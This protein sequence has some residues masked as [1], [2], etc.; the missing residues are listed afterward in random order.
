MTLIICD[1]VSLWSQFQPHLSHPL[2]LESVSLWSQAQVL[3]KD[4]EFDPNLPLIT[5]A[6]RKLDLYNPEMPNH[7]QTEEESK[8]MEALTN[9]A[10]ISGP[11]GP[12]WWAALHDCFESSTFIVAPLVH[13]ALNTSDLYLI[14]IEHEGEIHQVVSTTK[15][16]NGE[17]EVKIGSE[18]ATLY[19]FIMPAMRRVDPNGCWF[20]GKFKVRA[21][22]SLLTNLMV[23]YK[24]FEDKLKLSI[25]LYIHEAPDTD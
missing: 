8:E 2:F 19:D 9:M 7:I 24:G 4:F 16:V 15:V 13:L 23:M 21:C 12:F 20:P 22:R 25:P 18:G 17:Y 10:Q 14:W 6:S 5:N 3:K 1:S 11:N